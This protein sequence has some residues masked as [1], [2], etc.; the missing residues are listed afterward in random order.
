MVPEK[1]I[2]PLKIKLDTPHFLLLMKHILF[3][4]RAGDDQRIDHNTYDAVRK[5]VRKAFFRRDPNSGKMLWNTGLYLLDI[6]NPAKEMLCLRAP[7]PL[8]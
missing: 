7:F 3:R 6:L 2:Y 5:P 1:N 4:D 8:C